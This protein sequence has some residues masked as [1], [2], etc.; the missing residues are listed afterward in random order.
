MEA[1]LPELSTIEGQRFDRPESRGLLGIRDDQELLRVLAERVLVDLR[2]LEA[3]T[4]I[5]C[6]NRKLRHTKKLVPNITSKIIPFD[7]N[8]KILYI[9]VPRWGLG[10]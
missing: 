5:L 2:T 7:Q 1:S 8:G 10:S 4:R 9:F 3:G 6:A